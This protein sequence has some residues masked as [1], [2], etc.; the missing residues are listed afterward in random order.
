[1]ADRRIVVAGAGMGGLAAALALSA[2]GFRTIVIEATDRPGGK[3]R[4]VSVAGRPIDVGPT[5]LTM[6]WVFDR[7]FEEAGEALA[8]WV[9]LTRAER[10]GRHA[11]AD[12][13]RLDLYSDIDQSAAAIERFAGL[14]EAQGYRRFCKRAQTTYETLR[15][16]FIDG[17]RVSPVELSARIGFT[18]IGDIV[19]FAP[20]TSMWKALG[21]HF[22][23]PRLRQ[24]FGR[25]ATYCGS[26]PF[27]APATLMLVAHVEREGVWLVEGGM[28]RLAEALGKL[29]EA[30]GA[31]FR[32]NRRVFAHSRRREAGPPA[33]RPTT[34]SGS[35]RTRSSGTATSRRSPTAA[36]GP[37]P[38]ARSPPS[39]PSGRFRP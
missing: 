29:A 17:S 11:W 35:R 18:H 2:K 25:Y 32:L 1:M 28:A 23:D 21:D 13:S 24:L 5:V 20:F 4:S 26:S 7:L 33:S 34:E 8:D 22:Y 36:S 12:G 3:M 38:S 15:D 14:R 31:E 37:R 30:Q 27:L 6:R 39:R 10:L 9:T 19:R 16:S